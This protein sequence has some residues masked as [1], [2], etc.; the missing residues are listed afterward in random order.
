MSLRIDLVEGMRIAIKSLA[1][2][3]LRTLL[4]TVGVGIGVATLLAILGIVQGMDTSFQAQLASLGSSSVY[5]GKHPWVSMG[6]WWEFRNRKNLTLEHMEAVRSQCTLCGA[7][8]PLLD[9]NDD[10]EFMGRSLTFVNITGSTTEYL[11]V[12][13]FETTRGRFLNDTDNEGRRLVAV[14]GTDIADTFFPEGT[15]PIGSSIRVAGKP[16]TVIGVLSRKGKILDQSQDLTVIVPFNTF[17]SF[18]RGRRSIEIGIQVKDPETMDQTEDQ[19]VG[20]LR[21]ARGTPPEKPD[22]F[23]I[24]KPD[25]LASTYEQLTGALYG[26]ALGIGFITLLVGG[27][28]IMN[29]MLV[30]VRERTR[31]I[32]IRRALGAT[33]RTII[34]Q[35]VLEATLVSAVGGAIGTVV[36]LGGAKIVSLVTPLAATVKPG[37]V[38]FGIGF[39]ALVGLVFGI[40]PAARAANLDP[41]EALRD[42]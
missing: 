33:K 14:I 22:D 23:A 4:T 27:I 19:L 31:E 18:F 12:S 11:T 15:D 38:F 20:I 39:A 36:G 24:N 21:R 6:N 28:G 8:V 17:K 25:Q 1:N 29:I 13:G 3:R 2:H 26:V 37:T 9:D 16:F 5:V 32:G 7:V 30:S 34:T 10:V 40:W 35:F 42:E 41:V